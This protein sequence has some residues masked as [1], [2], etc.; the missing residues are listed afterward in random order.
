MGRPAP[1]VHVTLAR[2]APGSAGPSGGGGAWEA[3][4]AGR[5]NKDGRIGDLLPPGD[6]IQPGHY[7]IT[8]D[9]SEY[10]QR[11][12]EAHPGFFAPRPFYPSAAVEF[13]IQPHQ[14]GAAGGGGG[15]S[16]VP[17]RLSLQG[18]AWQP[19]AVLQLDLCVCRLHTG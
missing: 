12:R 1:G 19:P 11:C 6:Y 2:L 3:V 5:T 8:F 18:S 14:V 4:A 7:R 16:F 15:L 17:Q 9:T 13:E 10:M